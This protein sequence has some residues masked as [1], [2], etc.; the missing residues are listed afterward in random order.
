MR[1]KKTLN[2]LSLSAWDYAGCGYFLSQ[3]INETT[4][5]TSRAIVGRVSR[6]QFPPTDIVSR[7]E[8]EIRDLWKRADVIHIHDGAHIPDDLPPRPVVIT[9]HGTIYR[10]KIKHWN[11][12]TARLGW[13]AT[14][15]TLDL[16]LYGP[17][18]LPDCRPSD[19]LSYAHKY[20]TKRFRVCH[21]PTKRY[22]KSTDK[23]L[24]ALEANFDY[25]LIENVPW[26]KCL[27]RKGRC[28][29]LIDQFG[30]CYGCNAIEAWLMNVPVIAN[31][32][33]E[34]VI[35]LIKQ[36]APDGFPFVRCEDNPQAIRAALERLQGNRAYYDKFVERGRAYVERNHS[37]RAVA[38][39]AIEFYYEALERFIDRPADVQLVPH[40]GPRGMQPPRKKR[41]ARRPNHRIDA[42]KL[43]LLRYVGRRDLIT[44]FFGDKTEPPV[45]YEFGRKTK[46]MG[47]V[48]EVDV[49]GL[50]AM[51][52][53]GRRAF[54][55]EKEK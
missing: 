38:A 50:L 22:V 27:K 20:G 2:I 48:Y 39:M 54:V 19:I 12:E 11:K 8:D 30:L 41:A 49:P 21:A 5:H 37:Y 26:E 10:R 13:L 17:R 34:R 36:H 23:V 4:E 16:T 6:L 52:E 29:V 7:K 55:R 42:G 28:D 14:A 18:W 31:A 24:R 3:A 25:D 46:R 53:G 9:W 32:N 1:L 47:Y 35:G 51:R 44:S 40:P 15:A 33:N 45:R 43:V